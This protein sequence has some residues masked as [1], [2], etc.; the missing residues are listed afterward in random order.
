MVRLSARPGQYPFDLL[1]RNEFRFQ[2]LI[3]VSPGQNNFTIPTW[4]RLR[5]LLP[6]I[7]VCRY[8]TIVEGLPIFVKINPRMALT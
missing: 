4:R 2:V 8:P 6:P 5:K 3:A 7:S 1:W